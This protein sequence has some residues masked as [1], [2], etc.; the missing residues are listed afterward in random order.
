MS[1]VHISQKQNTFQ[2]ELLY[3]IWAIKIRSNKFIE[4]FIEI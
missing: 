4:T 1:D 3:Y 2:L